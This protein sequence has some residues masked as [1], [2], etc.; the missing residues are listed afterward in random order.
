MQCSLPMQ[1]KSRDAAYRAIRLSEVPLSICA[2]RAD[3]N[4]P[5]CEELGLHGGGSPHVP[6]RLSSSRETFIDHILK[7]P[8]N[9]YLYDDL[10]QCELRTLVMGLNK[11]GTEN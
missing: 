9:K 3:A 2:G 1:V 11:Q 6:G 10:S 5:T 4:S 7:R 8:A